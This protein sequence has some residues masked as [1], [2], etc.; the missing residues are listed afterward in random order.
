M[1]EYP[2]LWLIIATLGLGSFGLRFMFTGL[3]GSWIMPAWIL[4]HLRYAA[5]AVLPG[6]VAP[7]TLW[8]DATG[9]E[10]DPERLSAGFVTL[11]IAMMFKRVLL[12]IVSGAG[13]LF[14]VMHFLS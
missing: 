7:L 6:L 11:A 1:T 9:G 2:D 13:T 4:R 12:A 8:P 10:I 5:V 3:L 14:F